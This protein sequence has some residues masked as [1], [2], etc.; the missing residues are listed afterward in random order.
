[1]LLEGRLSIP[2]SFMTNI[3]RSVACPPSWTPQLPPVM[4]IGAGALQP[5]AVRQV[6]TP[7]PWFPPKPTAILTMDGT[8]ATHSAESRT[9]F[10][11]PLS[12]VPIISVRTVAAVSR[13]FSISDLSLSFCAHA[14]V[15]STSSTEVSES[16]TYLLI[17]FALHFFI[18][19]LIL[20]GMNVTVIMPQ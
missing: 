15:L 18:E 13:R 10:G 5:C 11:I 9:P 4:V 12:G 16:R 3:T 14:I 8:T 1:N 2:F 20:L 19:G 6:A 7:L 17:R